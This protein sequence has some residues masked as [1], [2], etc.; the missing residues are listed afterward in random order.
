MLA[1]LVMAASLVLAE[2]AARTQ[3]VQ[4]AYIE[5]AVRS[6]MTLRLQAM[7][8]TASVRVVG[9]FGDQ[10]LPTG[11]LAIEPGEVA[12]R[13][14]RSR[15]GVPVRLKVD[16]RVVRSLTAW[17]EMHD[18]RRVMTYAAT[19]PSHQTGA[20]MRWTP[21]SVDMACCAGAVAMSAEQVVHLRSTRAVRAG[22]P[23]MLADF[24]PMPDVQARQRVAIEMV[25]GPVRLQANGV[26]LHDGHVG[27]HVAVRP[28]HSRETVTS[29]VVSKQKVVVDE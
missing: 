4:A 29:R 22:Q 8:S 5:Q 2:P 21:A 3:R 28:D 12:G 19:Y 24:E 18:P 10:W 1:S 14:P 23:V 13:L 9:R 27:D 7:G 6:A 15:V 26:A 25:R 20:S 16:G 11:Q 17:V